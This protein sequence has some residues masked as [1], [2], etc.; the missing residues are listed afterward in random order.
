MKFYLSA[1]LALVIAALPAPA[2]AQSEQGRISGIVR[3]SSSAFV[4]GAKV[5]LESRTMPEMRPCSPCANAGAG[6]AAI[7]SAKAADR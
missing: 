5:L 2:F 7:T 6:N 1:A 3:D 4:A